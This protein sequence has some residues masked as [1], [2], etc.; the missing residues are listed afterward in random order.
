MEKWIERMKTFLRQR[1]GIP[2]EDTSSRFERDRT[3][4]GGQEWVDLG[5]VVSWIF[6]LED[7]GFR[8]R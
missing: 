6:R 4:W 7:G 2:A 3:M 5:Q 1:G 8:I